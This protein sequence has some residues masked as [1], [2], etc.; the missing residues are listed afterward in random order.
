MCIRH[1]WSTSIV[2]TSLSASLLNQIF[3]STQFQL[4]NYSPSAPFQ[5]SMAPSAI[6]TL[7]ES[8][9]YHVLITGG[10]GFV[11]THIVDQL[12]KVSIRLFIQVSKSLLILVSARP[13]YHR[14]HSRCKESAEPL[15]N[16]PT[17][18]RQGNI[19][20]CSRLHHRWSI[21]PCI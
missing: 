2:T 1:G 16:L 18:Q 21:R 17:L 13:H 15:H 6:S 4:R 8:T 11:A 7:P 20:Q 19:C 9:S 10:T 3:H 12:L 5:H 14:H